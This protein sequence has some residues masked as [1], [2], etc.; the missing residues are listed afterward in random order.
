MSENGDY[1]YLR[2]KRGSKYQQLFVNG[3]IMAEVLYRETVGQEALTPEQVAR[4]YDLPVEA[5]LESI[6]YC[7]HHAEI[8]FDNGNYLVV[9]ESS[10]SGPSLKANLNISLIRSSGGLV[11]AIAWPNPAS[12]G[13]ALVMISWAPAATPRCPWPSSAHFAVPRCSRRFSTESP[14]R[15]TPARWSR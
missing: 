5:V 3:R 4:E 2:P 13:S 6:H 14:S 15:W 7:T 12:K 9:A 8:R 11:S 10:G 1:Q